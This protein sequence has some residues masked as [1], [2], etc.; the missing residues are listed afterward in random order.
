LFAPFL[1]F[2]TEEVW[3][4]WRPG[5]IHK[6][7][8][9]TAD[10]VLAATST[11]A[12]DQGAIDA[13]RFSAEVLGAIRKKKSEE[14]RALKTPVDRAVIGAPGTLLSLLPHLEP[15][16]RAAGLIRQ[17]DTR[18]AERI[19]VEVVLAAPESGDRQG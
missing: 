2:A 9:P 3:S 12:A 10:E 15:D 6:A 19:E 14:Q 17:I 7:Q 4:W 11:R 1:P 8:W 16:L 5:S 13:L 18:A